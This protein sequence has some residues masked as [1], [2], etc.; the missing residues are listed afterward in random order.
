MSLPVDYYAVLDIH[1]DA[2]NLQILQAYRRLSLQ[3]HPEKHPEG[4]SP[5]VQSQFQLISEAYDVLTH[6]ELRA[7]FDYYGEKGLKTGVTLPTGRPSPAYTLS[8][9]PLALFESVFGQS[10][11]YSAVLSYNTAAAIQEPSAPHKP[12]PVVVKLFLSLEE[13]YHGCQKKVKVARKRLTSPPST[14][15]S[16]SPATFVLDERLLSLNVVA[17][18][19]AGTKIT[20][21]GEGDESEGGVRG[22]CSSWWRSGRTRGWRG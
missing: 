5:S 15:P 2:T 4:T 1:N 18:Y 14:S 9:P 21:E 3:W 19:R 20:F 16:P 13:L 17:G 6:P 10:S 8:T 22:M 7:V 11:P 12:A